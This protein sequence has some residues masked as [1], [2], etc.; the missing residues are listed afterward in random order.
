MKRTFSKKI[1]LKEALKEIE[2][3]GMKEI[4]R[5]LPLKYCFIIE[6]N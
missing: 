6:W 5:I 4:T 1:T 2:F 3:L